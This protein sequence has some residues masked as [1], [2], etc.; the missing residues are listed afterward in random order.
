LDITSVTTINNARQVI[1]ITSGLSNFQYFLFTPGRGT[2]LLPAAP[3]VLNNRG[4]ILFSSASGEYIQTSSAQV[5]LPSGY[6]WISMND[7]D[8]VV[9]SSSSLS[10]GGRPTAKPVYFSVTT[11]LI[12]L[13]TRVVNPEAYSQISPVAIN[14]RGEIAVNYSY[15]L[16]PNVAPYAGVG[17]LVP[18]AGT[19][20]SQTLETSGHSGFRYMSFERSKS[21]S[22]VVNGRPLPVEVYQPSPVPAARRR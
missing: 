7:A 20:V 16:D 9:G 1:G 21:H 3:I 12:D 6:S 18:V 13:T 22:Y 17:L 5:P 19:S 4:D 15:V 8:E 2:T 14:N 10:F 11:G